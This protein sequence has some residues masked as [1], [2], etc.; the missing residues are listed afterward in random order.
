ME[1]S[2]TVVINSTN[3]ISRTNRSSILFAM[4]W[5][6][7]PDG[8]YSMS[9]KFTSQFTNADKLLYISL[10]D[11]GAKINS[12]TASQT[13]TAYTNNIIG[14]VSNYYTGNAAGMFRADYGDN[15]PLRFEGK[16]TNNQFYVNIYDNYGFAYDPTVD[17]ILIL[18]FQRIS[19]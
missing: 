4:D 10:P 13:T 12:F 2:F 1:P 15:A 9:W 11:L 19:E 16:P 17:Y 7:L 8:K 6:F 5:S 14:T 18:N 3:Y